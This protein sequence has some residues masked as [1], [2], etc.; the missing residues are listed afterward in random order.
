[1]K[2]VT[3]KQSIAIYFLNGYIKKGKEAYPIKTHSKL[4]YSEQM[5]KCS[6]FFKSQSL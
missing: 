2:K 6:L 3:S 5:Y 1:M 4:H